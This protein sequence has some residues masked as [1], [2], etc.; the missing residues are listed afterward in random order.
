MEPKIVRE[1]IKLIR[2]HFR[3]QAEVRMLAAIL[4]TAV[5]KDQPPIGWLE[6]LKQARKTQTYRNIS[7]QYAPLLAQL[8]QSAD[9][10]ELDR[11]IG[12]IPPTDFLN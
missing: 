11:L 2:E 1:F 5:V 8:E 7:E 9:A 10:N 12:T 4:E 3:L 6:A